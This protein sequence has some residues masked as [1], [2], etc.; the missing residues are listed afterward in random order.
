MANRAAWQ[1]EKKGPL[2]VEAADLWEPERG[3]V[4]IKVHAAPV[5]PAEAKVAL[6]GILP[7]NYPV[8][9]GT[10]CAGIV[11]KLGEGVTKV[12]VGDRVCA[13]LDNYARR[14]DPARAS[15]Q[16]FTLAFEKEVIEIGPDIPFA[17]A[18]AANSQ[19]PA[20]GMYKVLG[21]DYP[22]ENTQPKNESVLIWGGSGAM[23]YLSI[24]YAKMAGYQVLTTASKHNFDLLKDAGADE[25]FDRNDPE[26]L[27]KLKAYLPIKFWFDTVSLPESIGLMYQ[28]AEAQRTTSEDDIKILTLLPTGSDAYPKAPEGV[29]AQ[30]LLF[31]NKLEENRAHVEWLMG[32]GGFLERGLKS[33]AI[34]GVPSEV[35]G[36]LD[37]VQ[38]ACEKVLAGVSAKKVVIDPWKE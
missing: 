19:Q 17:D 12:Q 2:T 16:R 14:G 36:G 22:E 31:R 29:S 23:G 10:S 11:D 38:A 15:I 8:V 4:R 25:V 27:E 35:V 3:E 18:V 37:S 20:N 9:L 26:I 1:K 28:L 7:L 33:G 6:Q 34:R 24:K 21:M 32:K 30:F 5:Q 13:G